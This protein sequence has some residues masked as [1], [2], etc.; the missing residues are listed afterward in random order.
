MRIV[1]RFLEVKPTLLRNSCKVRGF[2]G[3][4][5]TPITHFLKLVLLIDGRQ[6]KVPMLIVGLGD[7]GMILGQKWFVKTGVLIDCKNQRLIWPDN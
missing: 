1:E 6:I 4:Q 3:Q 2:D 5:T 7:H